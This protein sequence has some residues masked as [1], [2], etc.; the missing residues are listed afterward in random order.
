MLKN[1]MTF[2]IKV[3]NEMIVFFELLRF[4]GF[5]FETTKNVAKKVFENVNNFVSKMLVFSKCKL[6]EKST[7]S[8]E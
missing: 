2:K 1:V 7:F 6:R 5:V 8:M 3:W 4:L